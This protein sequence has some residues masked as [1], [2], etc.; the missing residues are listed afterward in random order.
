VLWGKFTSRAVG[1]M[2]VDVTMKNTSSKKTTSVIDDMEKV[3][4][5]LC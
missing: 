5:T 4:S 1:K 2:N 3:E